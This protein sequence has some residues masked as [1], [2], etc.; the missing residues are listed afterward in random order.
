MEIAALNRETLERA[1]RR[2][3]EVD[4]SL[5]RRRFLLVGGLSV[6]G[7]SALGPHLAAEAAPPVLVLPQA[8]GLVLA[9][10]TKCVGCRRCELACTEFND[11][12]AARRPGCLPAVC[13]RGLRGRVPRP[14]HRCQGP[15]ECADGGQGQVHRLSKLR[16]GLPLPD[17]GLRRG[18]GAGD[19]VHALRREA[20]V[21]RGLSC[22]RAPLRCLAGA[23]PVLHFPG[24]SG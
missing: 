4:A 22:G 7:L 18:G 5:S 23:E 11:G 8:K 19:Q 12:K 14:G 2:A 9:D 21:C 1:I 20:E 10:P 24:G 16:L 17:D 15:H 13:R 6:V 3:V